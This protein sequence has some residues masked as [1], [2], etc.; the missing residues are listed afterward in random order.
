MSC[1]RRT[2]GSELVLER[3]SQHVAT[4][5]VLASQRVAL[6][7]GGRLDVHVRVA[8]EQV[9]VAEVVFGVRRRGPAHAQRQ[10]LAA[11]IR[12]ADVTMSVGGRGLVQR[13]TTAQGDGIAQ[14]VVRTQ[15]HEG[16]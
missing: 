5:V 7:V 9:G 8:G 11:G 4:D 10:P 14:L 16:A 12:H 13:D 15:R 1:F 3:S 6:I 2:P